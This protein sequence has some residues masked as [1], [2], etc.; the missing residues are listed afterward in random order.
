LSSLPEEFVGNS[1]SGHI[2][3]FLGTCVCMCVCVCGCVCV[4]VYAYVCVCA[5][6]RGREKECVCVGGVIA[7]PPLPPLLPISFALSLSLSLVFSLC[8]WEW[9]WGRACL[10]LTHAHAWLSRFLSLFLSPTCSHKGPI[11]NQK[12]RDT[13]P[14]VWQCCLALSIQ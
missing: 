13:Q 4:C 14:G 12:R 11:Y 10:S 5:C 3:T 8:F 2:S 1:S 7:P 6:A 9:I